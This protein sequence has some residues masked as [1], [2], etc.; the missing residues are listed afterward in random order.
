V[1]GPYINVGEWLHLVITVSSTGEY[2]IY[3]NGALNATQTGGSVPAAATRSSNYIGKSN[4]YTS[5]LT[6]QGTFAYLQ[7][8]E[9][10]KVGEGYTLYA[11]IIN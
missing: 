7:M 11:L 8:W 3:K 9:V 2:N 10:G 6:F 4:F 1:A 5:D